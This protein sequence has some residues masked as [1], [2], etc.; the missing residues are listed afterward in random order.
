MFI[1]K[2]QPTPVDLCVCPQCEG[3]LVQPTTWRE[4]GDWHWH[5]CLRCPECDWT[6]EG[7]WDHGTVMAYDTKLNTASD[8]LLFVISV[9]ERE[10]AWD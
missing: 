5:I 6:G 10:A 9:L 2:P 8:D 3:H 4:F 1:S 7:V